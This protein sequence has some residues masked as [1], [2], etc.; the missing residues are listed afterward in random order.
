MKNVKILYWIFTFLFIAFTLLTSISQVI[1]AKSSV[2]VMNILKFPLYILPFLGLAKFF[3]VIAIVLPYFPKI[4]EW[5]YAGI[6]FDYL[7]ATYAMIAAGGRIDKWGFMIIPILLWCL[8]YFYNTKLSK[9]HNDVS[10]VNYEISQISN[11]I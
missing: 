3:G 6:M 1:S 4:K 7:G 11:K 8:S 9:I 5:A 10:K 2:E